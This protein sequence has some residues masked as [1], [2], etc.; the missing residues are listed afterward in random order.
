MC[1]IAERS[2]I[3]QNLSVIY[4]LICDVVATSQI[5][6]NLLDIFDQSV[7]SQRLRRFVIIH[8]LFFK[9]YAK[10]LR[11]HRFVKIYLSLFDN[12]ATSNMRQNIFIIFDQSL[13][14]SQIRHYLLVIFRPICDF[15]AIFQ[16]LHDSLIVFDNF[17]TSLR[18]H[19]FVKIYR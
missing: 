12:F 16:T 17:V 13:A 7:T 3:R 15:A 4:R 19:R 8:R 2:Q 1:D 14:T 5:F 11:R 18:R 9:Q 6:K 10:S